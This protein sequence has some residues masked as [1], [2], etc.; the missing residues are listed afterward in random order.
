[1]KRIIFTALWTM[2]LS[3]SWGQKYMG[4]TG[5]GYKQIEVASYVAGGNPFAKYFGGTSAGYES[6]EINNFIA[7][8]NPDARFKG[9]NFGGYVEVAGSTQLALP[10]VMLDASA[11][12]FGEQVVVQ[13]QTATEI[14]SMQFIIERSVDLVNVEVIGI[15]QAAGFS[16]NILSY[17]FADQHPLKETTYYRIK[18]IDADGK[19]QVFGWLKVDALG[20][21]IDLSIYP[22]PSAGDF[23][24]APPIHTQEIWVFDMQGN[25]VKVF[26]A[27]GYQFIQ[28]SLP[29]G[30]YVI[31]CTAD[32]KITASGKIIVK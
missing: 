22:N 5:S 4:G 28:T 21:N 3:K 1:M 9:G 18:Q 25:R 30:L 11:V 15:M 2:L 14:N 26:E 20:Q 12:R 24:I 23:T 31:H 6:F 16:S 10:V 17:E 13:W 27:T 29:S 8:G 19:H 32:G 7:G